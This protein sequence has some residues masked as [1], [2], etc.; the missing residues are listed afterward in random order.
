MGEANDRGT[1]EQ[2]AANPKGQIMDLNEAG[3]MI[4]D[5]C[6]GIIMRGVPIPFVIATIELIKIDI[7]TKHIGMTIQMQKIKDGKI[8]MPNLEPPPPPPST[9]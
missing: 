6:N 9:N 7:A 4:A 3:Q 8:P 2:R 5:V 1:R